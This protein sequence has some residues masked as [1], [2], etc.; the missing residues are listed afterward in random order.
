MRTF[1][2][3]RRYRTTLAAQF[4]CLCVSLCCASCGRQPPQEVLDALFRSSE[5]TNI[6]FDLVSEPG[7]EEVETR[8]MVE[9]K[10]PATGSLSPS[11]VYQNSLENRMSF[12]ADRFHGFLKSNGYLQFKEYSIPYERRN[13]PGR[14]FATYVRE[15]HRY[16]ESLGSRLRKEADH[17]YVLIGQRVF[18][19]AT[20]K[21]SYT[22][23]LMGVSV[24]TF[25]MTFNYVIRPTLPPM[26]ARSIPHVG[27][28]TWSLDPQDG[29]WKLQSWEI[30]DSG[31]TEIIGLAADQSMTSYFA[32]RRQ[33]M[34]DALTEAR[35]KALSDSKKNQVVI[36]VDDNNHYGGFGRWLG[37]VSSDDVI[38]VESLGE[39]ISQVHF[40]YDSFTRTGGQFGTKTNIDGWGGHAP[41]FNTSGPVTLDLYKQVGGQSK[42]ERYWIVVKLFGTIGSRARVTVYTVE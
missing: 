7:R 5:F 8:Q 34:V 17:T 28:A 24:P 29:K 36:E 14:T 16:Q 25:S 35:K 10:T 22:Q 1:T 33:S 38:S 32:S 15:F 40:L 6:Y 31:A 42:V 11:D 41:R 13:A 2:D 18:D 9:R 23:Q 27:N 12:G 26:D 3:S 37:Y 20:Y 4:A 21:N 30:K 19:G 39:G